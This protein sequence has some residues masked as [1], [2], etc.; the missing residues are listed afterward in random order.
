MQDY[1]D[2][3]ESIAKSI[4]YVSSNLPETPYFNTEGIERALSGVANG[5]TELSPHIGGQD[6]CTSL[7]NIEEYLAQ[8]N[9]TMDNQ[10]KWLHDIN[11]SLRLLVQIKA[12]ELSH[13]NVSMPKASGTI[14]QPLDKDENSPYWADDD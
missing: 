6:L 10:V 1:T 9:E 3:L 8:L 7:E 4:N 14:T 11:I 12:C 2:S 5:F 13:S